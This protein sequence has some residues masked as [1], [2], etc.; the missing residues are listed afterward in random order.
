MLGIAIPTSSDRRSANYYSFIYQVDVGCTLR[1]LFLSISDP[2]MT[3][4]LWRR[5]PYRGQSISGHSFSDS[6]Y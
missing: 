4:Q 6:R 2:L 5:L 3:P 1:M